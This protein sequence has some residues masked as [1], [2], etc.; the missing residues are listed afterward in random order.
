MNKEGDP[1]TNQPHPAILWHPNPGRCRLTKW[2]APVASKNLPCRKK[3]G[4]Q[5][6]GRALHARNSYLHHLC[7]TFSW[8]DPFSFCLF[9]PS[10]WLA[11][12]LICPVITRYRSGEHLPVINLSGG[13]G[14]DTPCQLSTAACTVHLCCHQDQTYPFKGAHLL[15]LFLLLFQPLHKKRKLFG[16]CNA[17]WIDITVFKCQNAD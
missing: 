1:P 15:S 9:L 2:A 14:S 6:R 4:L 11:Q 16:I 12:S 10:F 5:L 17:C 7:V 3:G 13:G 8:V